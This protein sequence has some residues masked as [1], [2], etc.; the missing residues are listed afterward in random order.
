MSGRRGILSLVLWAMVFGFV[1]AVPPGEDRRL[2][3]D[4]WLIG[5]TT[6]LGIGLAGRAL[7]VAPRTPGGLRTPI[8][9]PTDRTW[10]L[11]WRWPFLT[12][13]P[14]AEP[15]A[16]RSLLTLEGTV[17]ASVENPRAFAHRLRPRLR[18]VATHRLAVDRGIDLDRNPERAHAVLGRSAWLVAPPIG[19]ADRTPTV[20]DVAELLDRLDQNDG[21][22]N[23]TGGAGNTIID[24]RTP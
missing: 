2:S 9:L 23:G 8:R 19:E 22:T 20:D 11:G 1:I 18:A 10:V 21:S 4:L 15:S 3:I 17:A 16:P 14:E 5:V 12:V 24:E 6:W 13:P 7:G